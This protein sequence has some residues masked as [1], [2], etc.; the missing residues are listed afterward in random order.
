MS[1]QKRMFDRA[2]IDTD[3]FMDLSM[4]AKALY[5]LLGMEADDE[6]FVSPRKV[7]R[8]HGGNDDDIKLLISKGLIIPFQS[9]VVVITDWNNNNWL[10]SRRIK[11][12][13]YKEEKK[14][15]TL[16]GDKTYSLSTRLALV[17]PVESSI[18]E[19][20]TEERRREEHAP[21]GAKEFS[22]EEEL[23]KMREDIR[24]HIRLIAF[25]ILKRDLVLSSKEELKETIKRHSRAAV[26][27]SKFSQEKVLK[28]MDE[29]AKMEKEKGIKWTLET[30]LKLLTK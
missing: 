7:L 12:T 22:F 6:G 16:S 27:V 5:F 21:M 13:Q 4:S 1:A 8:I 30:C 24:I 3:R 29:C 18:E 15:L 19:R 10:D 23:E 9:G 26:S 28:I 14:L 20:S 17:K 11:P 2:I 25:F